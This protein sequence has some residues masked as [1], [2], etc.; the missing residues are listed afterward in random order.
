MLFR[1]ALALCI[2]PLVGCAT[3]VPG[4]DQPA[5]APPQG[6][7]GALPI[8]APPQQP[9]D[10]SCTPVEME[11]LTNGNFDDASLGTGWTQTPIVAGDLLIVD[12]SEAGLTAD[13]T[14]DVVWMGGY[15]RS[16]NN[17]DI[18]FQDVTIPAGTTTLVLT[19]SYEMSSQELGGSFDIATIELA[20][21]SNSSLERALDIDN[22]DEPVAWTPF[23]KTF[24][25]THAGETVRVRLTTTGDNTNSTAFFFD[26]LSL[27]ATVTPQGCP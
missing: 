19:G 25:T 22:S 8:D 27:K 24:T 6:Q 7:D 2:A 3:A 26:S 12:G 23:S 1:P 10:A 13:T 11:L 14:P 15:A 4:R 18:L 20:S 16:G 21:T 5:D 9:I 17:T